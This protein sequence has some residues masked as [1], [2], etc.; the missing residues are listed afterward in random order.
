[1]T[2]WRHYHVPFGFGY[3]RREKLSTRKGN[4]ILLEPTVAEAVSRA[5]AQIEAKN[6]ELENKDQGSACCWGWSHKFYDLKT[7]RT[8]GYDFDLEA[9]VSFRGGNWSLCTIC[10][11]S[12]PIYLTQSGFQTRKQLATIAWMILKAGKSSN[13]SKTSQC[14]INRAADNFE[15]SII[16]KF[17]ISL[18]QAFNKYY[19]HT[20]ILMKVQNVTAVLAF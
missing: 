18:A 12:Y 14:I 4:V 7:D 8:N 15:P 16:A 1:M 19:A 2:E 20:R 11:C 17:A 9:M 10:L 13:S 3:K 6:P 5:K